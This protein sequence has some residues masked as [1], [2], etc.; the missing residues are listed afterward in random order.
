[1]DIADRVSLDGFYRSIKPDIT[2]HMAAQALVLPSYKDPIETFRVNVMGTA[3]LLDVMQ[4]VGA[5]QTVVIVT[6]DKVYENRETGHAYAETDALGGGDPYSASKA[7]AEIVAQSF[8]YSFAGESSV[9]VKTARA[10]NVIGGGDWSACRL[11]P[12]MV[13]AIASKQDIGIRRP[14]AVRPWQHV[15]EPLSGYLALAKRTYEV[16]ASVP[17]DSFNFGP[18]ME[19]CRPVGEIAEKFLAAWGEGYRLPPPGEKTVQPREALLLHLDATR[20]RDVLDWWPRWGID[21]ALKETA[22]GYK[23]VLGQSP[24]RAIDMLTTQIVDYFQKS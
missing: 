24:L 3:T 22:D 9:T 19:S 13:R 18:K 16:S 7:C 11:V 6:T 10:G 15:L 20:A 12:D 1:A 14:D 2:I 23:A 5:P 21:R 4:K 8:I 17:F